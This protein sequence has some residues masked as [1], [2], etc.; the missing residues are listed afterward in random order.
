MSNGNNLQ[1]GKSLFSSKKSPYDKIMS[2]FK[3]KK[4]D[5]SAA[6][7]ASIRKHGGY[8]GA[9]EQ[10]HGKGPTGLAYAKDYKYDP[11][12]GE[13]ILDAIPGIG[14]YRDFKRVNEYEAIV[15]GSPDELDRSNKA[16]EE[17]TRIQSGTTSY[18]TN[19]GGDKNLFRSSRLNTSGEGSPHFTYSLSEEGTGKKDLDQ[20][21]SSTEAGHTSTEG[22]RG[23]GVDPYNIAVTKEGKTFMG[24][25]YGFR[26]KMT[27]NV[28]PDGGERIGSR[29]DPSY[30]EDQQRNVL[31]AGR[32]LR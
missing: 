30:F 13:K 25:P 1:Y 11:T 28:A 10:K 21:V 32:M 22:I 5:P 18:S 8:R 27:S 3:S 20:W 19:V 14:G 16:H 4:W 2:M 15:H 17:S 7:N 9:F 23:R 26:G 29:L 31:T 24:I 12:L 6:E